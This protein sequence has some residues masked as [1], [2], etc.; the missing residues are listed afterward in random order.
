MKP[1]CGRQT[2]GEKYLIF[3]FQ[4]SRLI[5]TQPGLL[6]RS[7]G[8]RPRRVPGGDRGAGRVRRRRRP[9]PV[10]HGQPGEDPLA[11]AH[12]RPAGDPVDLP[13]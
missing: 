6:L 7:V 12:V 3:S 1:L 4:I 10:R 8:P 11:A 9:R 2:L 5:S 13:S